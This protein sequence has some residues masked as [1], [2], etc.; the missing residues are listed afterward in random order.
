MQRV[1]AV[2]YTRTICD[3]HFVRTACDCGNRA[4]FYDVAPF[5]ITSRRSFRTITNVNGIAF[6]S[7]RHSG[8]RTSFGDITTGTFLTH[9]ASITLEAVQNID[10]IAR[11]AARN[12]GR[13]SR[14]G[15]G[16][17]RTRCTVT[18]I[19]EF[20]RGN[21]GCFPARD[22]CHISHLVDTTSG[23]IR[24][25]GNVDR[26]G[27]I[28]LTRQGGRPIRFGNAANRGIVIFVA[29]VGSRIGS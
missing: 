28:A 18:S 19:H 16:T 7:T 14:L 8:H 17:S 21:V 26:R 20:G 22:S 9:H 27:G 10:R 6:V 5:S 23:A 25:I 13:R 3:F 12:S 29:A 11:V 24:S 15:H 2:H 1:C 4:S